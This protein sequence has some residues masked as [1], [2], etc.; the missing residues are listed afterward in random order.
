MWGLSP[1]YLTLCILSSHQIVSRNGY[2]L[3]TVHLTLS[4]ILTTF[5][6]GAALT[7]ATSSRVFAPALRQP[8]HAR[9]STSPRTLGSAV[10]RLS[11]D[12]SH[13]KDAP[14]AT[15]ADQLQNSDASPRQP[16]RARW[17][18]RVSTAPPP[19]YPPAG[20]SYLETVAPYQ[21]GAALAS[22]HSRDEDL[23]SGSGPSRKPLGRRSSTWTIRTTTKDPFRT[24]RRAPILRT[25]TSVD[26]THAP[27][28]HRKM[29]QHTP[30]PRSQSPD[31]W[32]S[33]Q[34]VAKRS[35]RDISPH[36][37]ERARRASRSHVASRS[38]DLAAAALPSSASLPAPRPAVSGL[39]D[40]PTPRPSPTPPPQTCTIVSPATGRPGTPSGPVPLSPSWTAATPN[41]PPT[42]GWDIPTPC[43]SPTPPYPCG[44][45]S[46][47][48]PTSVAPRPI[49]KPSTQSQSRNHWLRGL[50]EAVTSDQKWVIKALNVDWVP[51]PVMGRARVALR[52]D[53]RFGVEDP[54]LWP[55][56]VSAQQPHLVMIPRRPHP[57]HPAAVLWDNVHAEDFEAV[58]DDPH[59]SQY[60]LLQPTAVQ[61][62]QQAVSY[63][64]K[65]VNDRLLQFS[66]DIQLHKAH[67]MAARDPAGRIAHGRD[68]EALEAK[69]RRLTQLS[70]KLA[71]A[72]DAFTVPSTL[73][74]TS[75]QRGHLHR[76]FA[77]VWAWLEWERSATIRTQNQPNDGSR[78]HR[79][80]DGLGVMGGICPDIHSATALYLAGVPTWL[81]IR[82]VTTSP[83]TV[84]SERTSQL[85]L[86]TNVLTDIIVD[87]GSSA[88]AGPQ[89]LYAIWR[90]SQSVLDVEHVPL[91]AEHHLP[92]AVVPRHP[93]TSMAP[94]AKPKLV[95]VRGRD[96]VTAWQMALETVDFS[97]PAP[98]DQD[99]LGLWLPEPEFVVGPTQSWRMHA[100]LG[101]WLRARR[102]MWQLLSKM[103]RFQP[104][105]ANTWRVFIG[106]LPDNPD[107][108]EEVP[109]PQAER[110]QRSVNQRA[111]RRQERQDT[112]AYFSALLKQEV[113]S[114]EPLLDEI[115]WGGRKLTQAEIVGTTSASAATA[116]REI[117]WELSEVAFRVELYELDRRLVP[118]ARERSESDE[119]E[120]R[121]LIT[122]VFPDQ[123]FALPT[124][125]P[126]PRQG[127]FALELG[128]RWES[129]EGLRLVMVR[130]PH[131]PSSFRQLHLHRQSARVDL[132]RFEWEAAAFYCQVFYENF[133]RA[134]AVPRF[135]KATRKMW[136]TTEKATLRAGMRSAEV[137]AHL[138]DTNQVACHT[139]RQGWKW[140]PG[141]LLAAGTALQ[142]FVYDRHQL[143]PTEGESAEAHRA[144]LYARGTEA[145]F[146]PLPGQDQVAYNTFFEG[147]T[148]RIRKW[149]KNHVN[150][151]L[152]IGQTITPVDPLRTMRKARRV[153]GFDI[154]KKT[155]YKPPRKP[156]DG[157]TKGLADWNHE[158]SAAWLALSAEERQVYE[159]IASR[160]GED[161]S[162]DEVQSDENADED[163]EGEDSSEGK[164]KGKSKGQQAPDDNEEQGSIRR[165]KA[166]N[167]R[168]VAEATLESWYAQTGYAGA[169]VLAGLNAREEPDIII[170]QVGKTAPEA[171]VPNEDL[172]TYIERNGGQYRGWMGT[173]LQAWVKEIHG[174]RLNPVTEAVPT[175]APVAA[176]AGAVRED[177]EGDLLRGI[178]SR[179]TGLALSSGSASS[180]GGEFAG[181]S[182]PAIAIVQSPVHIASSI[183]ARA[184][185]D[186]SL[187]SHENTSW[188][189]GS[190]SHNSAGPDVARPLEEGIDVT[191]VG[192][193][194]DAGDSPICGL[195]N[196]SSVNIDTCLEGATP[197]DTPGPVQ[198]VDSSEKCT[199]EGSGEVDHQNIALDS[200]NILHARH[201]AML[202][203]GGEERHKTTADDQNLLPPVAQ[204]DT[205]RTPSFSALGDNEDDELHKDD[206]GEDGGEDEEDERDQACT[207]TSVRGGRGVEAS[208]TQGRGRGGRRGHAGRGRGRGRGS[209]VR[210]SEGHTHAG[211][212]RTRARGR[213]GG[214][215]RGRGGTS[216]GGGV[217][218]PATGATSMEETDAMRRSSRARTSTLSKREE[219]TVFADG[220]S[221]TSPRRLASGHGVRKK[222]K[223]GWKL[224]SGGPAISRLRVPCPASC[225]CGAHDF[226]SG[227]YVKAGNGRVPGIGYFMCLKCRKQTIPMQLAL[228][229]EEQVAIKRAIHANKEWLEVDKCEKNKK[230]N[231][232]R[233]AEL[234]N[235]PKRLERAQERVKRWEMERAKKEVLALAKE[236]TWSAAMDNA[237]TT[238]VQL[239][240]RSAAGGTRG[241][242]RR[243]G[244]VSVAGARSTTTS[245]R[246]NVNNIWDK[247]TWSQSDMEPND[248]NE[249][250]E[251]F[252]MAA[253]LSLTEAGGRTTS[254]LSGSRIID[255]PRAAPEAV[256]QAPRNA[257][258]ER[259][260]LEMA[261]QL[262]RYDQPRTGA[263]S[264][265]AFGP[266][267]SA[268]KAHLP[269]A[270]A[271]P[272][273]NSKCREQAKVNEGR[274]N[275]EAMREMLGWQQAECERE[276]DDVVSELGAHESE[277]E[278]ANVTS[279]GNGPI[280]RKRLGEDNGRKN[281]GTYDSQSKVW[282][283][284]EDS[285]SDVQVSRQGGTTQTGADNRWVHVVYWGRAS[286]HDAPAGERYLPQLFRIQR[287]AD[288]ILE[289]WDRVIEAFNMGRE[290]QCYVWHV[291]MT[292]WSLVRSAAEF[293]AEVVN[294][295]I[296]L[297]KKTEE[298]HCEG[299]DLWM[300]VVSAGTDI[301]GSELAR[302]Q[303]ITGNAEVK[304]EPRTVSPEQSHTAAGEG[305]MGT[306]YLIWWGDVTGRKAPQA[307]MVTGRRC[308]TIGGSRRAQEAMGLGE[309]SSDEVFLWRGDHTAWQKR[310]QGE[311]LPATLGKDRVVLLKKK[312]VTYCRDW[313]KWVSIVT[314]KKGMPGSEDVERVI[315]T[316]EAARVQ[317]NDA[318]ELVA[319]GGWL[320]QFYA[321]SDRKLKAVARLCR[322]H[323]LVA[324]HHLAPQQFAMATQLSAGAG[325]GNA[326]K[327][328]RRARRTAAEEEEQFAMSAEVSAGATG[329][330][331]GSASEGEEEGDEGQ[332]EPREGDGPVTQKQYNVDEVGKA[333]P[334]D[335][336]MIYDSE[337]DFELTIQ[338]EVV[339]ME[340]WVHI[341]FWSH[342]CRFDAPAERRFLP[343]IVRVPSRKDTLLQIW[344]RV[345]NALGVQALPH[346]YVWS[347]AACDWKLIEGRDALVTE[348]VNSRIVLLK[349]EKYQ[350]CEDFGTWLSATAGGG[351][352]PRGEVYRVQ[353]V[354]AELEVQSGL[355][356]ASMKE[357][358][359]VKVRD[360]TTL[361]IV[362]WND[363]TGE[364]APKMLKTPKQ[365]DWTIH[366]AKG[367]REAM[368]LPFRMPLDYVC[369]WRRDWT[370]WDTLRQWNL[371][372]VKLRDD[373]RLLVRERRVEYCR[374]FEDWIGG[375]NSGAPGSGGKW[376]SGVHGAV[377]VVGDGVPLKHLRE[378]A[379]EGLAGVRAQRGGHSV[380]V[381]GLGVPC[382]IQ[383]NAEDDEDIVIRAATKVNEAKVGVS[384]T[385]GHGAATVIGR[386]WCLGPRSYEDVSLS[387]ILL[388]LAL[389]RAARGIGVEFGS[390]VKHKFTTESRLGWYSGDTGRRQGVRPGRWTGDGSITIDRVRGA[391]CGISLRLSTVA[392]TAFYCHHDVTL[393]VR[394]HDDAL[395]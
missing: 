339:D 210:G 20:T 379:A 226:V 280:K 381:L 91:P 300:R 354:T 51:Q 223:E 384:S 389:A 57:S 193:R 25:D 38:R 323:L 201:D 326:G 266:Q 74:D 212:G 40:C 318:G 58:N 257:E 371:L 56:L 49:S 181:S 95:I 195:S 391:G 82:A 78:L 206:N 154:W 16:P 370:A 264:K 216:R 395:E 349:R 52:S 158:V 240:I 167:L 244:G 378:G 269:V 143:N 393:E 146:G 202:T 311:E 144:R 113:H 376:T 267:R 46:S 173:Q 102:A 361:D 77:E 107:D 356:S 127:L 151:A 341:V 121:K 273:S 204:D 141:V 60:G 88:L 367:L 336:I 37:R 230:Y 3:L 242:L 2:P 233:V 64:D 246:Q 81:L 118:P 69:A 203:P 277:S 155:P 254:G 8:T 31:S 101:N 192:G 100:Y 250:N 328:E 394:K 262:S 115:A 149:C 229:E 114:R 191:A 84:A 322:T 205:A 352:V 377:G 106:R 296:V 179:E 29:S 372:P 227:V 236:D 15:H 345:V 153:T 293:V 290:F 225:D 310:R 239:R 157:P 177:C 44:S 123:H 276:N 337:P 152:N 333:K 340:H 274:I 357:E 198:E 368:G 297:L 252:T 70:A 87:H 129:L 232:T 256:F 11:D 373:N 215:S 174:A 325:V 116:I 1:L 272:G 89:H 175:E 324:R 197:D 13:L 147:F 241:G 139:L 331:V 80:M 17:P 312:G 117:C 329:A 63:L 194:V 34:P 185:P 211:R 85:T 380:C 314:Q 21:K 245:A 166:F 295:R 160:E 332:N 271:V 334:E 365:R 362:W 67:E 4:T 5:A 234:K 48:P 355:F 320:M 68:R 301:P 359:E 287:R 136:S 270:Q 128:D 110:K 253:V 133:G 126:R 390:T 342:V 162:L 55:Q 189:L 170:V 224:D 131:S 104:P 86:P 183:V 335:V 316:C 12:V 6:I 268:E 199:R 231:E 330:P 294:S 75:A 327:H 289:I 196:T 347:G 53:G 228:T 159:D 23:R 220:T 209:R 72:I 304:H 219:L 298:L 134:A 137:K 282:I 132:R 168:T 178:G 112:C 247:P 10:S 346:G 188:A 79:G 27:S 214:G 286:A 248:E 142:E 338:G 19:A 26:V 33:E 317:E 36:T 130:W 285:D 83:A 163:D 383:A 259:E 207:S 32:L 302:V 364:S 135:P 348:A 182:V 122:S 9:T 218:G 350:Y 366:H 176:V 263:S 165:Q 61:K 360:A 24:Q 299:F 62:L 105:R 156:A 35:R 71:I 65:P 119:L 109:A 161:R 353:T 243:K 387:L 235:D 288:T 184:G 251:Q 309:G 382:G 279:Q 200:Q 180:S 76:C 96:R 7:L 386:C 47:P 375:E 291:H 111:K 164:G 39:W 169:F 98:G 265:D 138:A 392:R 45:T 108:E 222:G 358:R 97:R 321:G 14:L 94:P 283:E 255:E 313:D 208:R 278:A 258:E 385:M 249:A 281:K 54:L 145:P 238:T 217:P 308:W 292:D 43:R 171:R 284:I 148:K 92:S 41:C 190:L 213:G 125:P 221:N 42:P 93:S 306:L 303:A 66:M 369:L 140:Q 172:T 319:E 237:G 120:R 99:R 315:V 261:V 22:L 73:R 28:P 50:V 305:L 150:E 344:D 30:I 307:L 90:Y 388:M 18:Q 374:D 187:D 351:G 124:I 59:G 186:Y 260:Q 103:Q 343:R 275:Q 363:R